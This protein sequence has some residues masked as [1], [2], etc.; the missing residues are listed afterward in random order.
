MLSRRFLGSLSNRLLVTLV[1]IGFISLTT[2]V[3]VV[4][5]QM[6]RIL[7][8]QTGES[9]QA[10]AISSSQRLVGE[11]AREV[12]L[13][14]NL[15]E[16]GSFFFG[17]FTGKNEL[18]DRERAKR[19]QDQEMA[20]MNDDEDLQ[21]VIWGHPV[22][23]YLDR[24]IR[25][26]P[27]HTQIVYLDRFGSLVTFGGV[28]P[29]NFYYGDQDWWH[30]IWNDGK[31]K[32]STR[33]LAVEPGQSETLVEIMIPVRLLN[34]QSAVGILK[35]HFRINSLDIFQDFSALNE[36]GVLSIVDREGII[37]HSSQPERVGSQL[38]LATRDRLAN[39]SI[40]WCRDRDR[41]GEDTIFGYAQLN[42]NPKQAYLEDLGW[43]LVVQKSTDKALATVSYLSLVAILGATG[44]LIV[45][46]LAS[47]WIAKQFTRP[48]EELTQTAS[49]MAAGD[50]QCQAKITGTDEFRALGRAFNSMTAQLRQSICTLEERV[51]TRTAELEM[52]KEQ[53]EV[54]NHAKSEFLANMSHELRTPL[55]AILGYAQIL[56]YSR[57]LETPEQ[58]QV[59][60]IY[61]SGQHLLTLINDILDLA[62]IEAR[63]LEILPC[64]L[65]LP[66]LLQSVVEMC[67]IKAQQKGIDFIYQPSNRL[68]NC[69]ATDEKRLR[70]VLINLLGNAI[71]FTDWGT[72]TLHIDVLSE[73]EKEVQLFFQV[74]DTGVGIAKEHLAQLFEAFEQVG[75]RQKK[76]EGTGLG[77]AISQRIVHLMGGTIEVKSK[78]GQGSEFS[79]VIHLAKVDD[80]EQSL[81][82]MQQ[83]R[84]IG[85]VGQRLTL[86]IVDDRWE[87]RAVLVNLLEPLGFKT[88]EA[89]NGE[90][91][92]E[93]LRKWQAD[94]LI[95][96]LAMP[97]M[98]GFQL[99]DAIRHSQDLKEMKILVSSASVSGKDQQRS[100]DA[101]GDCFLPKPVNAQEL[102]A[103][104]SDC[105][106][107]EWIYE[108]LELTETSKSKRSE[109][110]ENVIVPPPEYLKELLELAH[111]ADIDSIWQEIHTWEGQ[112]QQFA[113]LIIDFADEFKVEEIEALLQQHLERL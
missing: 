73:S 96:D 91:G 56:T 72:V 49:A 101:G 76:S 69:I 43:T 86:L 39:T 29:K 18:S 87:N 16:D 33:Q 102:Y 44:V 65:H 111:Q 88:I 106:N 48:I 51:Q 71:K 67:K 105:L 26:F 53:A 42:P 98:D 78:L 74:I 110:E 64:P 57:A 75:D 80:W 79:F 4:I 100:I 21:V 1:A 2:L 83:N 52:A 34:T 13:L 5:W 112:Y 66:T 113:T 46:L 20:W 36:V 107:L 10:L 94:F 24:F 90:E 104:V 59:N 35:A 77:L 30:P 9:F 55:N 3:G 25:K 22:K 84:I 28:L 32:F 95:T 23:T 89:E 19:L 50:L 12:E 109:V 31:S 15:S 60:V 37:V 68:P 70:Q 58:K 47:H 61:Q 40:G 27:A 97:V 14:T 92:L 63:K 11:L 38:P 82:K 7:T 8:Q 6:R 17:E 54:A 103:I 99:I 62:K 93:K 108:G 45:V 81:E 85:Y 41:E